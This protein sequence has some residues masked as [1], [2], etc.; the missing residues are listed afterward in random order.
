[1]DVNNYSDYQANLEKINSNKYLK[2]SISFDHD[3]LSSLMYSQTEDYKNI[4]PVT[5]LISPYGLCNTY[6][7]GY[8]NNN[9][10]FRKYIMDFRYKLNSYR[11]TGYY[12]DINYYKIKFIIHSPNRFP[13]IFDNIIQFKDLLVDQRINIKIIRYDFKRLPKPYDTQCY[14]YRDNE[15]QIHC[16]NKC[17]ETEY[18]K[19]FQ[20]IP[21]NNSLLTVRLYDKYIEPN[22]TFCINYSI[23]NRHD[24]NRRLSIWCKNQ[25]PVQ[26]LDSLYLSIMEV[27]SYIGFSYPFRFNGDYYTSINYSATF[28]FIGLII[29]IA[30][31][32]SLWHGI[33]FIDLLNRFSIYI[34][35]YVQISTIIQKCAS[36]I[37]INFNHSYLLKVRL[38]NIFI[39]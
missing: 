6:Y 8:N 23:N 7:F 17:Y 1:M 13:D 10:E 21:R 12:I 34:N 16:I 9:F 29:S 28:T 14:D 35:K 2:Q 20:C 30:N 37:H 39:N 27:S 38:Y 3:V 24:F 4:K 33:S 11:F 26:C 18:R 36:Y 25:C 19:H 31:I 22:V 32:M 5:K 15:T